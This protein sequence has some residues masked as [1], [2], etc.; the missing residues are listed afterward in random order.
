[1]PTV[2]LCAGR[3]RCLHPRQAATSASSVR[4]TSGLENQASTRVPERL[5]L[6]LAIFVQPLWPLPHV[7]MAKVRNHWEGKGVQVSEREEADRVLVRR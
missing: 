1:V 2:A 3:S 4:V 7:T 5:P 6:S